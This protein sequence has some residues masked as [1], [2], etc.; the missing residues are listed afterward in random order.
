MRI[1]KTKAIPTKI[2]CLTEVRLLIKAIHFK[3]IKELGG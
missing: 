1:D 2:D 3:D